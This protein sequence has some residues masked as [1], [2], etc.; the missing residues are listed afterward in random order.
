MGKV[1]VTMELIS[2]VSK[3]YGKRR[4]EVGYIWQFDVNRDGKI[5]YRDIWFFARNVGSV[6][7]IP[8]PGFSSLTWWQWILL[9][10]SLLG[11]GATGYALARGKK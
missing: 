10:L 4:G 1:L 5:D 2:A 11:S 3:S 9:A 8:Q 6:V 7:D